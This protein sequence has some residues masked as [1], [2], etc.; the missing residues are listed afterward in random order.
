MGKNW[1]TTLSSR[2]FMKT[3]YKNKKKIKK[4]KTI[5]ILQHSVYK[6]L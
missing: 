3:D 6:E 4:K 5:K 2:W 1:D